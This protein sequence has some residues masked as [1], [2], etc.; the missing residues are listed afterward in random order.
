MHL[1]LSPMLFD[2]LGEGV[3]VAG[4]G[5]G[6]E[7]SVDAKLLPRPI[8]LIGYRYRRLAGRKL[9]IGLPTF[10]A[11]ERL[12]PRQESIRPP[13]TTT[14][15]PWPASYSPQAPAPD[16]SRDRAR[17]RRRGRRGDLR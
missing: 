14:E 4:L 12:P 8:C 15:M 13:A 2:Q 6:D 17:G 9:G 3:G 5:S 1:Q 16:A 10:P 7:I 11:A